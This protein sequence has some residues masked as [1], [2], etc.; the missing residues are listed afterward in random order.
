V[1]C[2]SCYFR[3]SGQQTDDGLFTYFWGKAETHLITFYS[4]L[5]LHLLL[6]RLYYFLSF[7]FFSS[8][9]LSIASSRFDAGTPLTTLLIQPDYRHLDRLDHTCANRG[10]LSALRSITVT[11][12]RPENTGWSNFD[13][14]A[15][16]E[17]NKNSQCKFVWQL[18]CHVNS[19]H[20]S[21][22]SRH[23]ATVTLPPFI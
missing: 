19:S 21:P 23:T 6:L 14:L 20:T 10:K 15:S 3:L 11:K 1:G 4:C 18:H 17:Y 2:D 13:D 5:S 7:P 8:L 12:P 9:C 22:T 16:S